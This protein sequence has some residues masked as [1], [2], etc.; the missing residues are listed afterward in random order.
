M[1][2]LDQA[3]RYISAIMHNYPRWPSTFGPC[4]TEDCSNSARGSGICPY[5]YTEKLAELIGED[6]ADEFH[7]SIFKTN[8]IVGQIFTKLEK[9]K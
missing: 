3:D 2:K 4:V 7:K 6:L 8:K 5:C 1:S 9:K